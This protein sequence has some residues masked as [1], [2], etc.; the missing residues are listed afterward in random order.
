ML[1]DFFVFLGFLDSGPFLCFSRTFLGV[2]FKFSK[3]RL[4]GLVGSC[5][6][7]PWCLVGLVG[8]VVGDVY[9]FLWLLAFQ[10]IRLLFTE[11]KAN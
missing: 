2:D 1:F 3:G 11:C 8:I 5:F 10:G 6:D 9:C 7:F 4:A